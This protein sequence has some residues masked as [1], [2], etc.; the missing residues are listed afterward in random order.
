MSLAHAL[1]RR[2][3]S[4]SQAVIN[5]M[6]GFGVQARTGDPAATKQIYPV[7]CADRAV[8]WIESH[9]LLVGALALGLALPQVPA[10]PAH[11]RRSSE[12][13]SMRV[14]VW[15]DFA[16]RLVKKTPHSKQTSRLPMYRWGNKT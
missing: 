1:S 15:W 7:G 12:S 8:L 10:S 9:L 6:C 2:R 3:L 14:V 4:R 5:T 16:V 13:N 11:T